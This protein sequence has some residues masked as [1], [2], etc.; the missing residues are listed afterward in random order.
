[1][2][3]FHPSSLHPSSASSSL[4]PPLYILHPVLP[5]SL[6]LSTHIC[7]LTPPSIFPPSLMNS[8]TDA[9]L[10]TQPSFFLLLLPPPSIRPPILGLR[11]T[12]DR[13]RDPNVTSRWRQDPNATAAGPPTPKNCMNRTRRHNDPQ[14]APKR[15]HEPQERPPLRKTVWTRLA[16]RGNSPW[17]LARQRTIRD[18]CNVRRKKW[19]GL[20]G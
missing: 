16:G 12:L 20:G 10:L 19:K 15:P 9:N 3:S 1:M 6:N 13:P 11:W 4:L 17:I 5:A 18:T 14:M 2:S 7:V 8:S